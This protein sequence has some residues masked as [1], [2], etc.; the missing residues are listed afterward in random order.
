MK[1]PIEDIDLLYKLRKN[2]NF[3]LDEEIF[4]CNSYLP[5]NIAYLAESKSIEP[6]LYKKFITTPKVWNNFKLILTHDK[7]LIKLN[8]TDK[9]RYVPLTGTWIKSPKVN[10]KNKL[11]S[12]ITSNKLMCSGHEK[13]LNYAAKF[14][15]LIDIYGKGINPIDCKEEGLNDYM[16]SVT[17]ENGLYSGYFTEKIIDCFATGTIPVYL[18]APDI[19]EYFDKNGIIQLDKNFNPSTVSSDLYYSKINSVIRNFELSKKY[20]S[21][22]NYIYNEHLKELQ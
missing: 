8:L 3:Y 14:K 7:D 20:W 18:G 9:M 5:N 2:W 6:F 15:G 1:D 10:N 4:S 21:I 17:I 12:M 11:I 22:Q 16:F 19:D 13:R